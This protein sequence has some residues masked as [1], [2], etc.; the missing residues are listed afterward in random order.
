[1]KS[2]I[3]NL[4]VSNIKQNRSRSILIMISIFLTTLLL[5]V[6]ADFGYGIVR[7]N[8]LNAGVMYGNYCGTFSRV[9]E[10]QYQTMKLRS[11]FTHIGRAVSVAEVEQKDVKM[12]LGWMDEN[13]AENI[14]FL[15]S[16][17][18][19]TLPRQKNEITASK[20]FFQHLGV[21]DPKV[22]DKVELSYRRDNQSR[23]VSREFVISGI[24]AS[25][26]MNDLKG[27]YQGY[28]SQAFYE[29]LF[30]EEMR[31]YSVSFRL[32]DSVEINGDN[33]EEVLQELGEL[34]GVEKDNVSV[35]TMYIM[36]AYDPGTETII[37]C[38]GIALIVILV[39]V[40]VIYN[41][42]Q[43]GIVQK[44]QEYGKLKAIGATRK[45]LKKIIFREGMLLS[46][47][48]VPLGILAGTALAAVL[49]HKFMMGGMEHVVQ[50]G[51]NEV[52]VVSVPLLILVA[53]LSLFTVWIA[54]KRPMRIVA[55]VSAVEAIRYQESTR[56]KKQIR[57]GRKQISV[58]G[59]TAANLSG[60]RR[61]T[62]STICTMGLSCVLFVAL[63]NFAGNIDNEYE[64]RKEVE[65]GQFLL[66]L[67]WSLNDTAYPEN[68]LDQ[69]Q[70]N[71]PL[72]EEFQEELKK[73]PG[74]TEVRTRNLFAA[75]NQTMSGKDEEGALTSIS[76]MNREEFEEYGKGTHLGTVD[77][78][79]ASA[80]DGI[81][82]GFSYFLEDNGYALDQKVKMNLQSAGAETSYEGKLLGAFGSAPTSWVI[83]E[84]TYKK[85]GIKGDLTGQVWV[86]CREDQKAEV[87]KAISGLLEGVEHVD[88]KT[89]ENAMKSVEFM[90]GV[91]QAGIYAFLGIL[92]VIGFMNMA[93][94]II[95]GVVTRKRELGVLQAVGMTKRQLNNMLQLEG[96]LFSAGTIMVSLAV[97]TPL[98]YWIFSYAKEHHYYGIN[99][100]HF[101][102]L[103]IGIMIAAIVAM[104]MVLSF[105]LSRNLRKETL[106]ERINYQG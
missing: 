52:S 40:V 26:E 49:F 65:Y 18:E 47:V 39:S 1:M 21:E 36:W 7:Y 100:Y 106:V 12:A 61:R 59:M 19:G 37:G 74:V 20:E 95:T 8:R 6:I 87:E 69:I 9:T 82:F 103:E 67:D 27:A 80:E 3:T 88:L 53:V 31:S 33:E 50:Q 63:S 89:Y 91:M 86:D 5:S 68:N 15:D 83:T 24:A 66:E 62:I 38:I 56:R 55:S 105:L 32:N 60:N 30:P 29:E 90:S 58:L 11:E 75:E 85:L 54:L 94:T 35:N 28:V 43:V 78:D 98:G 102:L 17:E 77:Y 25:S 4:A 41:I 64:A 16:M 79:E 71:N 2:S 44:I 23:F 76:V 73:I 99:E 42:F 45:Q 48:A 97:G 70:K 10:E 72:G 13:A 34:C 81:I 22:G 92:G 51:L 93:N 46:L 57:K 84:D 101:P 104:Q 96:I 14:N